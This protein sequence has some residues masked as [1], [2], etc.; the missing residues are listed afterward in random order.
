M[1]T[2][3]K[4]FLSLRKIVV[5][6]CLTVLIAMVGIIGVALN[7]VEE[8]GLQ[9]GQVWEWNS[10]SPMRMESD[11]VI[12]DVVGGEVKY[13]YFSRIAGDPC[14]AT[15]DFSTPIESFIRRATY[16]ANLEMGC[17]Q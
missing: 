3:S 13:S 9:R 1:S 10:T 7:H 17:E 8:P 4:S 2:D 11:C 6:F 5:V 14:N 16:K 12:L 15:A